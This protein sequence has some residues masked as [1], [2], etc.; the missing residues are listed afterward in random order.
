MSPAPLPA[1]FS[2]CLLSDEKQIDEYRNRYHLFYRDRPAI[3][4]ARTTD[5]AIEVMICHSRRELV[6]MAFS[7]R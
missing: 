7:V 1:L 6:G 5:R 2:L 3:E 4:T